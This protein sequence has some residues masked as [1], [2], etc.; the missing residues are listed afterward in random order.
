MINNLLPIIYLSILILI[1]IL[2]IYF[3]AKQVLQKK[4]IEDEF[5]LLQQQIKSNTVTHTDYYN[6]GVIYLSKKLFDQAILNFSYALKTWDTNDTEG[7]ANLYNAIGFTY[8]GSE[9]Y[10]LSIYYYKEAIAKSPNYIVALNN[11]AYAYEKKQLVQE[12]IEVYQQVISYD[13]NNKI[14]NE[15]SNILK[16]RFKIRDDRI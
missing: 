12:A 2:L 5:T 13:S 10:D 8:F 15:K 7:I 4:Q 14:A 11:L 9:Q 6:V 16:R 3:V 1:L